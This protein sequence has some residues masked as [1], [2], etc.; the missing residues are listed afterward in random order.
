MYLHIYDGRCV[1]R[2]HII[3]YAHERCVFPTRQLSKNKTTCLRKS[4]NPLYIYIYKIPHIIYIHPF[5]HLAS[6]LYTQDP[7]MKMIGE[8]KLIIIRRKR[9]SPIFFP[10]LWMFDTYKIHP[11]AFD[12]FGVC[13]CSPYYP[14]RDVVVFYKNKT[15]D[16]V[17]N[18]FLPPTV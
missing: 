4:P 17:S 3:S 1:H 2:C 14:P 16:S 12:S 18:P 13:R 10:L 6:S 11:S 15:F 9:R 5:L 7:W 8:N